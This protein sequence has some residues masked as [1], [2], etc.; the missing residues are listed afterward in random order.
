M[1]ILYFYAGAC[2]GEGRCYEFCGPEYVSECEC[3]AYLGDIFLSLNVSVPV[4]IFFFLGREVSYMS[5]QQ[6]KA[7][8]CQGNI[9]GVRS[10]VR[11]MSMVYE[12]GGRRSLETCGRECVDG[13]T[14]ENR[15]S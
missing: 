10:G 11:R 9:H 5:R 6:R 13:L 8:K 15:G 2:L 7:S 14:G 3:V 12:G 4:H 1:T